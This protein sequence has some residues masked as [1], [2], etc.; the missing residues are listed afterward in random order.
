MAGDVA[1]SNTRLVSSTENRVSFKYK[2]NRANGCSKV[3]NLENTEF[4]RRF[5]Q[6]VLPRNFYKIRYIGILAMT[7]S[8]TKKGQCIALMNKVMYMPI[9]EGLNAVDVIEST[10]K[11]NIL[12]CPKCKKGRMVKIRGDS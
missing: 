2:D 12:L 6:H 4:I 10:I 8:Q 3:M 7:N 11:T 1:I 5:L 9:L